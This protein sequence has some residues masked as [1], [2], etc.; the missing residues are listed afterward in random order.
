MECQHCKNIFST[1]TSLNTH[2]RTAKYCIRLQNKNDEI[3]NTVLY[4]CD[5]CGKEFTRQGN[6]DRHKQTCK[7][8]NSLQKLKINLDNMTKER[9]FYKDQVD[10]LQLRVRELEQDIKEVAVQA[11]S[12]PT[13][14]KN[15]QINNYIQ[16]MECITDE[17]I[18]DQA[19]HL[20]IE[21][22][23]KGPEGYAEYALEYPLKNRIVCVDYA[24]RKVKF[25]DKEGNIITDPEM[26]SVATKLFES[27]K[28][29]NKALIFS[30]GTELRERFGDEMDTVVKLL[31]YK[32]DVENSADGSKPDF[33]HDFVRS[34]CGKTILE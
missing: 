24:R 13:T 25:K 33:F 2:Q 9:D 15:T 29:R 6:L 28:D 14:T 34:V 17:H 19:Q 22:I 12:R 5:K 32:N 23:Q 4:S 11:V 27:I 30:Y 1:K 8:Q 20:T 26:S 7:S 18:K 21:H 10:K 3:V 16:K 31:E